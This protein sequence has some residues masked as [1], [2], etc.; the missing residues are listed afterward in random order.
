MNAQCMICGRPS[1]TY[2]CD[3]HRDELGGALR[4]IGN[5]ARA[6]LTGAIPAAVVERQG[7]YEDLLD[8]C[9]RLTR[10]GASRVPTSGGG[11]APLPLADSRAVRLRDHVANVI[12]TWARDLAERH[13]FDVPVTIPG[14]ATLL[15]CYVDLIAGHPSASECYYDIAPLPDRIRG[16]VDRRT[17][18]V[19]LGICSANIGGE[20]CPHD[21]FADRDTDRDLAQCRRCGTWHDVAYRRR[22]M[23]TAMESQLLSAEDMRTVLTRYMPSGVPAPSTL[24]K[25]AASGR[26]AQRPPHPSRPKAMRYRVGDVLDLIAR[27]QEG[28][29]A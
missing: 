29:S 13:G 10:S 3:E 19:F 26:I 23:L 21:V 22:V 25:W 2:L 12:S 17:D 7:L 5:S 16:V 6:E 27:Q 14:A 11:E 4:E 28:K 20:P 1:E 24:R 8:S 18:M 9:W 15:A